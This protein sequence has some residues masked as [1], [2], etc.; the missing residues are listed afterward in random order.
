MPSSRIKP[1][2]GA[3][4]EEEFGVGFNI[5]KGNEIQDAIFAKCKGN[6]GLFLT[7]PVIRVSSIA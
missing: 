7:Q 6:I 2:L 1:V 3:I 4:R 5:N